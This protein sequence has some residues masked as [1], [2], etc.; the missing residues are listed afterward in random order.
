MRDAK[1]NV[2][3][4]VP[5]ACAL[6]EGERRERGQALAETIL[7]AVEQV[8][9][10]ADG[11]AFRFPGDEAWLARLVEFIAAERRCCPFFTFELVVEPE[12]GP[13]W[14]QLR[15]PEGVKPFIAGFAGFAPV[16]GERSSSQAA[17]G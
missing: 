4:E 3:R 2:P 13:L 12:Q 11:Y 10:L 16:V 17:P 9:E 14:L 6:P 15:G 8:A 7:P 5:I 1:T